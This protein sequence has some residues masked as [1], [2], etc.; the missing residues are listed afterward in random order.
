MHYPSWRQQ[1]V[2]SL[3]L[4]RS[5]PE[6]KYF[7]VASTSL[8]GLPTLRTM[9]FRQFIDDTN[10]L[11]S[12]TDMRS[13][14]VMH[15]QNNYHTQLHWYFAKTREQYR[16]SCHVSMLAKQNGEIVFINDYK[17]SFDKKPKAVLMEQWQNLSP[18]ARG[19]FFVPAPKS[20]YKAD[21]ADCSAL[22]TMVI[23][24]SDSE[25]S[26]NS[27][28][29]QDGQEPDRKAHATSKQIDA[30]A[31][32]IKRN[33]SPYF[34]AVLFEPYKVDYLDLK[35]NPHTRQLHS[36]GGTEENPRPSESVWTC[37]RVHA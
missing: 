19:G 31:N 13:D 27:E 15:W 26:L 23:E 14:K 4:H 17:P 12:V 29:A 32:Y 37:V 33:P 25:T 8:K 22:T 36:L 21:D 24:G 30:D 28:H 34:V 9:V 35:T 20:L 7:Q 10:L 18:T 5:K 2:R 11:A 1:L 3:H 6:A 16:I